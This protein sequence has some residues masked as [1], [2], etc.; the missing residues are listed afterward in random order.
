MIARLLRH[1][2]SENRRGGV[3]HRIPRSTPGQAQPMPLGG[4]KTY[5][6][7]LIPRG[8]H[9]LRPGARPHRS[10]AEAARGAGR[11]QGLSP[12]ASGVGKFLS[13]YLSPAAVFLG[14]Y[15][16]AKLLETIVT[17]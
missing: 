2:L 11:R 13:W 5:F 10:G 6:G 14:F 15:V 9:L 1:F 12:K 4:L 8:P 7:S 16:T 3:R 17:S